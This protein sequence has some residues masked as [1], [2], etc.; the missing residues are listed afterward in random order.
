MRFGGGTGVRIT[1]VYCQ[2]EELLT[3]IKKV[4]KQDKFYIMMG[5]RCSVVN[6]LTKQDQA[7]IACLSKYNFGTK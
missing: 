5:A 4:K 7:K 2:H 1:C 3:S 6:E